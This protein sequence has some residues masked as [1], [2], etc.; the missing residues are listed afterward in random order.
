MA[1][2]LKKA[3]QP[4]MLGSANAT[5]ACVLMSTAK[6]IL[7]VKI[8][9]AHHRISSTNSA[10]KRTIY[11]VTAKAWGKNANTQVVL[12]SYVASE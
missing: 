10:D 6:D 2:L 4:K 1:I 3:T 8:V 11:R 7:K 9:H 5:K 12:Q